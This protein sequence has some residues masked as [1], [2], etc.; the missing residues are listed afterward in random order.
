MPTEN[1]DR[2]RYGRRA[3][4]GRGR[5]SL[6]L[7]ALVWARTVGLGYLALVAVLTFALWWIYDTRGDQLRAT[8]E[9]AEQNRLASVAL[10]ALRVDLERRVE[11]T[12]ALLEEFP[13]GDIYG[14][15]RAAIVSS[16]NNQQETIE[17]LKPLQCPPPKPTM[18]DP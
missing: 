2:I 4:D 12:N 11:N 9:L 18:E 7:R 10:C 1:R 6:A 14:I 16:R 17:A 5:G 15:P 13:M 3:T 8:N